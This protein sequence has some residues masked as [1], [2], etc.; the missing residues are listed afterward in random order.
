[1]R[2]CLHL[3]TK[4]D[5]RPTHMRTSITRGQLEMDEDPPTHD[6]SDNI[7]ESTN[8][9]LWSDWPTSFKRTHNKPYLQS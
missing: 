4:I 8:F 5:S 6:S 2:A 3:G 1:M 9:E 7:I